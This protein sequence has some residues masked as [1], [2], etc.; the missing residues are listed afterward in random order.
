MIVVIDANIIISG[1]INPYGPIPEILLQNPKIDFIVP[2]YALEEI[3]L[4]KL[5]VCK[6]TKTHLSLFDKLQEKL[7]SGVLVFSADGINSQH[8][9]KA[10]K[11]TLSVDV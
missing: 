9:G 6:E 3:A 11:L 10:R 2:G 8:I 1:I 5:R 7:L 4:H